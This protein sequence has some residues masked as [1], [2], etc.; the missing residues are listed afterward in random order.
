[1]ALGATLTGFQNDKE[2]MAVADEAGRKLGAAGGGIAGLWLGAT[3]RAGCKAGACGP[4]NTFM[5][6]D[7]VTTGT[8][9]LKWATGEPDSV[10]YP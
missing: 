2:R 9:G 10:D 6:T 5:W 3:T 4:L 8:A 7:G 1:M